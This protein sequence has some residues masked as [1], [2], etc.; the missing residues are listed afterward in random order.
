MYQDCVRYSVI[1][2]NGKVTRFRK[3]KKNYYYYFKFFMSGI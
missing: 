3:D 2:Y 1:E